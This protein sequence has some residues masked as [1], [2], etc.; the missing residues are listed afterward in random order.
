MSTPT[1]SRF[2]SGEKNIQLVSVMA[3]LDALG[4]IERPAMTFPE[5][6]ESYDSNRDVVLF[7]AMTADGD[8]TCAISGDALE[9]HCA[10]RGQSRRARLAA[11]HAHRS[12]I[13]E[14]AFQKYTS[15]K[16]EADGSLLIRSNDF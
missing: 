2:E 7:P 5:K 9:D 12:E 4:M 15:R 6:T 3:I 13:E 1:V 11:F 8:V 16:R 10:A 14:K